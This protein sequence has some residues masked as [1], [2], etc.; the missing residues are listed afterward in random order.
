MKYG[1]CATGFF[2]S[3]TAVTPRGL[4]VGIWIKVTSQMQSLRDADQVHEQKS[5]SYHCKAPN[6][7]VISDFTF[8]FRGLTDPSEALSFLF[9]P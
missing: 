8:L 5:M 6:K 4:G 7:P 1:C 9:R 3:F 2:A